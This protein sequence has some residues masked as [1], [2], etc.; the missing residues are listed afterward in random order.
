MWQACDRGWRPDENSVCQ[1][2]Q[3]HPTF[4]DW[5]YLAFMALLA[6]ALHWFF[7]DFTNKRKK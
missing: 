1:H 3:G 2:C 4:Y 5:L 7:I 6:P